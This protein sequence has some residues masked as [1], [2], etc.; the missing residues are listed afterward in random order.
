MTGGGT[1]YCLQSLEARGL[2]EGSS[3]AMAKYILILFR[4]NLIWQLN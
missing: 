2:G 4:L 3:D 1:G